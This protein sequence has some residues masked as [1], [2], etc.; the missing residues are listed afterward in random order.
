MIAQEE[1]VEFLDEFFEI[2]KFGEDKS[3]IFI[4]NDRPISR[5]GLA[6]EP[7]PEIDR[8]IHESNLDS[9]FLHR[10]WKLE[11][12]PVEVGV[13]FYHHAF[14]EHL[15]IG[16][17]PRLATALGMRFL[18]PF[19]EKLG[20]PIGMISSVRSQSIEAFCNRVQSVFG[21]YEHRVSG[22]FEVVDRVA[23]VG[24]LTPELIEAAAAEGVQVYVTGQLRAIAT[25]AIRAAGIEVIAVGHRRC[26]EWGLRS[27]ASVLQE[28]WASLSVL[29]ASPK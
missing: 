22:Q 12:T 26:E 21:R 6:L 25:D 11:A 9:L 3:G 14:D 8:W 17:N 28:R 1:L 13:V 7:W 23:V 2:E 18:Q 15:T 29:V 19:G 4:A 16:F 5:V 27:L 20:R 10:P 24:A